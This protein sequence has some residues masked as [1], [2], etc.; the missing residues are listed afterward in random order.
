MKGYVARNN[1]TIK[2]QDVRQLLSAS[3]SNISSDNWQKAIRH[4][5][6]EEEKFWKLD[7]LIEE[8]VEPIIIS[9]GNEET[10][11]DDASLSEEDNI[12]LGM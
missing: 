2:L 3:I 8:T 9:V 4:V 5:I 11:N 10:D 12:Y 1:T 7:L 6:A